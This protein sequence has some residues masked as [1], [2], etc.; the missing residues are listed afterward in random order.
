MADY[1]NEQLREDKAQV[2]EQMYLN[3]LTDM[4][5]SL[6]IRDREITSYEY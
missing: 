2:Y 1:W 5:N 6:S 3:G 4:V